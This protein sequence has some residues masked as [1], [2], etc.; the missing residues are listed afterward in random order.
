MKQLVLHSLKMHKVQSVS[1]AVSVAL[2]VMIL[3]TFGLVYG[4]VMQ[5]VE[6]SEKQGGADVMAI[7]S[8]ALQYIGDTELLY[9]G[10]PATV[11]MSADIA[12]VIASVDGAER[13]SP[14]FFG[15]TLNK[16]CCSTTG[17]TRLIGID[18]DTDF[19]VSGLVGEDA[20]TALDED[21]VIVGAGVG[22][23]FND[24]L[25][26]Y[27]KKYHVV[28]VMD[29]TG[30]EFDASIVATIDVVRDISREMEG[31]EHFWEKHGD[32][33][34]LI[35]CVMIDVADDN[36][37]EALTRVK[38]KIN[39]A[40]GA[41][42]LVR[43]DIVD[44][45]RAQ[46]QSVFLLLLV[47]A[48]IMVVVTLLQLFARFYSTVWDRKSELALYRAIGASKADLKKLIVGEMGVLVGVGLVV[49]VIL[50]V[51]AQAVLLGVLQDGLSFPYV[52]LGAGPIV[53]LVIG[54]IAVFA[55]VSIISIVWPLSQIGRLDPSMA[56]QQGDID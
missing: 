21:S 43:S 32:P 33:S 19:V 44:K 54:V 29:G 5:G 39:L 41:S 50:G 26:I 27:D 53:G 56:M 16:G 7:P 52:A 24:E 30:T 42:P 51:L 38:G 12:D 6:K 31:F 35:S 20:V 40:G 48:I 11:Y 4:G 46:L 55:I 49:G 28:G 9:T 45:S 10:A 2:S 3:V 17:E 47:A 34:G 37:G 18:K 15:Q 14:Q 36:T 1:I 22:G 25:T 8:D 13:V 23:V